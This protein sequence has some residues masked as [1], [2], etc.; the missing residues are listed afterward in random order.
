MCSGNFSY[1]PALVRAAVTSFFTT[2]WRSFW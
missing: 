1:Q 2:G